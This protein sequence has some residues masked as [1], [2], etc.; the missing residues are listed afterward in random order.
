MAII[1]F[2]LPG[3]FGFKKNR[4]EQC[5]NA[6]ELYRAGLIQRNIAWVKE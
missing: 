3:F 4:N 2:S 6:G 5:G 1:H